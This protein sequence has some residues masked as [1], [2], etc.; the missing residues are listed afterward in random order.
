MKRC[1]LTIILSLTLCLMVAILPLAP[2]VEAL[3]ATNDIYPLSEAEMDERDGNSGEGSENS[4]GGEDGSGDGSDTG[5]GSGDGSDNGDGSGGSGDGSGDGSG[6]GNGSSAGNGSGAGNSS[7]GNSSGGTT[8]PGGSTDTGSGTESSTNDAGNNSPATTD[9]SGASVAARSSSVINSANASDDES[10]VEEEPE[11]SEEEEK[12][13]REALIKKVTD[14]FFDEGVEVTNLTIEGKSSQIDIFEDESEVSG[15]ESGVVI[16]TGKASNAFENFANDNVGGEGSEELS[17]LV[18][19]KDTKDM[20]SIEFEIIPTLDT[21]TL[22]YT[23]ASNEWSQATGYSD[24]FVI[25]V[26]G[27][28]QAL[29]PDTSTPISIASV[30]E[31]IG[32]TQDTGVLKTEGIYV[33]MTDVDTSFG[34]EGR[35]VVIECEVSVIPEK[36]NQIK[37]AIADTQDAIV[38]SAIFLK[39]NGFYEGNSTDKGRM[40]EIEATSTAVSREENTASGSLIDKYLIPIILGIVLLGVLILVFFIVKVRKRD[41][42][43]DEAYIDEELEDEDPDE[44]LRE[45]VLREEFDVELDE[46][47]TEDEN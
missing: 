29:I 38:D 13:K 6:T 40:H 4:S 16:S 30:R 23:F 17:K 21:V 22:T 43:P 45:E 12:E 31:S 15:F 18:G 24:I 2:A 19:D 20:A 44:V 32:A 1:K 33:N 46:D 35:T 5:G 39:E 8:Q 3:S 10:T 41:D 26:N 25:M 28:N 36:V 34:F 14:T 9:T 47:F 27:E 11:L 37:I 7:G 42:S